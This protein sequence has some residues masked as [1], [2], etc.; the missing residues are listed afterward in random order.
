MAQK[1]GGRSVMVPA[2]SNI[3]TLRR[4]AHRMQPQPARQLLQVMKIVTDWSLGL[5]PRRFGA[6]YL[7]AKVDLNELGRVH[8]EALI[9]PVR[10]QHNVDHVC[11]RN[12]CSRT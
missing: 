2:F 6:E 11:S 10:P 9:L 1:D 12:R 8:S 7:G 4:L 3:R 5:E